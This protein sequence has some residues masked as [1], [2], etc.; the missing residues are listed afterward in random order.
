MRT[1]VAHKEEAGQDGSALGKRQ[2]LRTARVII[3]KHHQI[4]SKGVGYSSREVVER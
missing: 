1:K 4:L 2:A 3:I